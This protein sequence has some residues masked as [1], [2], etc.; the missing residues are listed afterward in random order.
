MRSWVRGFVTV[1][2]A[3]PAALTAGAQATTVT[4]P[5]NRQVC[6]MSM[7][8]VSMRLVDAA[9]APVSGATVAVRR[10]RTR[11]MLANAEAMGSQGDYK[12]AEDGSIPGLRKGGEPF[13][14]T[15]TK[16]GRSRRVRVIL[17]MDPSGC[18]LTMKSSQNAVTL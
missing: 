18:H 6:D 12:I 9:G 10:V 3:L 16:D 17:G 13:D 15:F 1:C 8:I 11:I 4:L 14:V 2:A 5:P 7:R